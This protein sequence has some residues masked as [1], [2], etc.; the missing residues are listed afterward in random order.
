LAAAKAAWESGIR[1]IV[2]LE[3]GSVP[4][5]DFTAMHPQRLRVAPF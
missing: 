1:D 2:I 5:R 3:R 4:G